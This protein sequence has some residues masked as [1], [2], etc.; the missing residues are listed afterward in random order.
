MCGI[1]GF[2]GDFVDGLVARMNAVQIHRGP[3]GHDVFEDVQS[4]VAL[5]H[6]RLSILDLSSAASQPMHSVDGRFVLTYNGEIYNFIELRKRLTGLGHRFVSQG[7][8]E[9]LLAALV[10]WGERAIEEVNGIFAFALWDRQQ[11]ELLLARDPMGVKPLYFAQPQNGTL[12]FASEIKS[13]C[14]YPGLKRE[15]DF[16]ALHQHLAYGHTSGDRTAL[17]A[18]RRLP[19]GS[20]LRWRA[21]SRSVEISR[22]WQPSFSIDD[23]AN[24]E[25]AAEEL[26]NKIAQATDRQMVS[27][28]PV[29]T[30]LSGGLDSSLL[31]LLAARSHPNLN[32]YTTSCSTADNSLDQAAPDTPYARRLAKEQGLALHEL[33]MQSDVASLWPQLVFHLDEPLADPAAIACYLICRSAK[34]NGTTV[35]LSGQGADELFGGYPRYWAM[36]RTGWLDAFP[37]WSRRALSTAG[38]LLP[39]ALSGPAGA[40][41]RRSRRVLS[42]AHLGPSE[43]FL[44]LCTGTPEVEIRKVLA[45]NFLDCLGERPATWECLD[46]MNRGGGGQLDRYLRRDQS[47]YLP[48]HNLLYTDKMSMAVGVETRVPLLDDEVVGFANRLP[49]HQKVAGGVTKAIL[50][51]A[52]RSIVPDWIIDR[53]K[54]GFGAPY[55]TWLRNDLAEMWLDL[56]SPAAVRRRGWFDERAL[57][58]IRERSQSGSTD[59]YMLQWAVLTM[60]IWAQQ[61]LD[62]NPAET[63][64][65]TGPSRVLHATPQAA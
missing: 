39:G 38:N 10:Q 27:D 58:A 43:R 7:D 59:L 36:Q 15:P 8:T 61:F 26:A 13:L 16:L 32:C 37:A 31:T 50:R 55:R 23:T 30:F 6:V 11:R 65:R 9:V 34:E 1:A 62:E 45:P 28:V 5:G 57:T 53:S 40:V 19:P 49:A 33:T 42:S 46:S 22:Y 20:L 14:A 52:A 64:I 35:L 21:T 25:D 48:N 29:G 4:S 56:T 24:R 41:L 2:V 63:A 44:A 12:L 47:V 51:Q 17:R 60:E 54:A 3:D 18:V